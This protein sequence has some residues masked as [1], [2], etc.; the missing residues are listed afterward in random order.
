MSAIQTT[1]TLDKPE[2]LKHIAQGYRDPRDLMLVVGV[3]AMSGMQRRLRDTYSQK[4]G[5]YRTGNLLRSLTVNDQGQGDSDAIFDLQSNMVTVG[6]SVRYAA[7]QDEGG[8]IFPKTV[9]FLTIPLGRV[10]RQTGGEV[11][12]WPRDFP[13]DSLHFVPNK[14]GGRTAGWLFDA[15]DGA[16]GFGDGPLWALVPF[17]TIPPKHMSEAGMKEVELDLDDIYAEWV[18][19]IADGTI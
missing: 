7:M 13:R 12:R 10:R 11:S 4:E 1:I 2:L 15:N 6:S 17:V 3:T 14:K 19:G 9:R 16:L 18:E 5:A 8:D